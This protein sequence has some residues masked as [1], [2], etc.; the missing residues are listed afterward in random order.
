MPVLVFP[1][2]Q[3]SQRRSNWSKLMAMLTTPSR[4]M[5]ISPSPSL[6]CRQS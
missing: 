1:R 6:G 4:K 5:L 2:D 3:L